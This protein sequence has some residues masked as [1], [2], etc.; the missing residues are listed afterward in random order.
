MHELMHATGFWHEQSRAD[1]C[2]LLV[3]S[4]ND[5]IDHLT[6]HGQGRPCDHQLGEHPTGHGVQLPQVRLLLFR[7]EVEIFVVHLGM[8]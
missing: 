3:S 1:R 6:I 8:T 2:L 4:S 7:G 5:A